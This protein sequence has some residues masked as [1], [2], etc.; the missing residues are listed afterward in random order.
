MC[1]QELADQA[2]AITAKLSLAELGTA[3]PARR[4]LLADLVRGLEQGPPLGDETR[5]ALTVRLDEARWRL[6][7]LETREA[8]LAAIRTQVQAARSASVAMGPGALAQA[9][10][11]IKPMADGS[12]FLTR[13]DDL[14]AV[15]KDTRSFSSDKKI[16]FAPID[17]TWLPLPLLLRPTQRLLLG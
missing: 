15:Y 3:L 5:C 12:Y 14:V 6:D 16:E 8:D 2:G 17:T 1:L 13:Y 9:Q 11:P 10:G 4:Q 7:R